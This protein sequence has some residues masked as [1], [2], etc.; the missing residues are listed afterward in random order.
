MDIKLQAYRGDSGPDKVD[1]RKST[2][3]FLGS[4]DDEHKTILEY[5]VEDDPTGTEFEILGEMNDLLSKMTSV[6]PDA[7]GQLAG[8]V[9]L[10]GSGPVKL[11]FRIFDND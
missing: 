2:G 4:P 11:A 8:M 3:A 10:E 7:V 9:G 6:Q 5:R 1:F